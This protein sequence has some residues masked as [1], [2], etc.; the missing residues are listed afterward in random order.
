MT[1]IWP[2]TTKPLFPDEPGTFGSKRVEDIHTGVDLYCPLGTQVLAMEDGEVILV[3]GFTGPDAPDPSPW[4]NNTDAVLIRGQ[5]GVITYGEITAHATVGQKVSKG[6]VIG[7]VDTSVLKTFKGRPMV[8]LHVELLTHDAHATVWW[9]L[10]EDR[11]DVLCDPTQNL[12]DAGGG[13]IPVFD[14][15]KY[16]GQQFKDPNAPEKDSRWWAFWGGTPK[17]E[18]AV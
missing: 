1:W 2:L 6:D 7:V 4:W 16:D 12:I 3:E 11:P 8:M 18:V 5:S 9:R 15:T 14:L 13:N 10:N 17:S